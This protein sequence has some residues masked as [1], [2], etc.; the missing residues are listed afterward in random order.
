MPF[1]DFGE[2]GDGRRAGTQGYMLFGAARD[3][4]VDDGAMPFLTR[5]PARSANFPSLPSSEAFVPIR[6][7][8]SQISRGMTPVTSS[9]H[10]DP[11]SDLVYRASIPTSIDLEIRAEGVIHLDVIP[12]TLILALFSGA[13]P[14]HVIL[15]FD[16]ITPFFEGDCMVT[17]F[18]GTT[19]INDVISYACVIRPYGAFS[20]F[21]ALVG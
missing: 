19:P 14:A 15:G 2:G 21:P 11:D 16:D 6:A 7:W 9:A 8:A 1:D 4:G 5:P 20:L 12:Q 10:Y 17:N 13:E 18:I 3:L